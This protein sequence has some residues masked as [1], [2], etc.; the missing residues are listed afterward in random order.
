VGF[1]SKEWVLTDEYINTHLKEVE[2]YIS[3]VKRN[4]WGFTVRNMG[5]ID[6]LE[7][8]MRIKKLEYL[9]QNFNNLMENFEI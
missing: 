5:Y 4:L 2:A 6:N 7:F 8:E 9:E 1:R 3:W